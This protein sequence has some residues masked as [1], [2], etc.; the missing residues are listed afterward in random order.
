MLSLCLLLFAIALLSGVLYLWLFDTGLSGVLLRSIYS[1]VISTALVSIAFDISLITRIPFTYLVVAL[2]ITSAVLLFLLLRKRW[3][4]VITSSSLLRPLTSISSVAVLV[5]I[6]YLSSLFIP[7]SGR[8]GRWDARAIWTLHAQFMV[9]QCHWG[10][11]FSPLIS[12]THAD[13]PLMLSSLIA[14]SWKTLGTNDAIVPCVIAYV[15]FVLILLAT[16][17][18]L[19][20][21]AN[22]LLGIL[23]LI[24]FAFTPIFSRIAAYQGADTL[25]S[26]FI[27]L[28]VITAHQSENKNS[29]KLLFLTGIIAGFAGWVKNEGLAFTLLFSIGMLWQYCRSP[30]SLWPYIAGLILPLTIIIIFKIG[31]AP[32][33]DIIHGQG[34]NTLS[35]LTDFTL[36]KLTATFFA[37]NLRQLYPLPFIITALVIIRDYKRLL[38]AHL[39]I[40]LAMLGVYFITFLITPRAL[41]WHLETA[42]ERLFMQLFPAFVYVLLSLLG[43]NRLYSKT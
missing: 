17:S 31:Y 40:L 8:W 41:Q 5:L 9:D 15:V 4:L 38:D 20:E 7:H 3:P 19:K 28:A 42:S 1:F 24:A 27:L 43:S 14:M 39:F 32:S 35:H 22:P 25:L 21:K 26:L 36:Y 37:H 11:M 16:Y 6:C 29:P 30:K 23:A 13:Y 12:W 34:H 10:N 33:N 18:G 2:I